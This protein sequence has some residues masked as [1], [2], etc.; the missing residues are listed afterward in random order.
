MLANDHLIVD[1]MKLTAV[2]QIV[3]ILLKDPP[4]AARSMIQDFTS[5]NSR[6]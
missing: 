6:T 4:G 2:T 3:G 1:E 5:L